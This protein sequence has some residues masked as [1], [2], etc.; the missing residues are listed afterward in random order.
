MK[1]TINVSSAET[2]GIVTSVKIDLDDEFAVSVIDSLKHL[3]LDSYLNNYAFSTPDKWISLY[4]TNND[5]HQLLALIRALSIL[6]KN[7]RKVLKKAADQYIKCLNN[8]DEVEKLKQHGYSSVYIM[9]TVLKELGYN[10]S[11]YNT[12]PHHVLL[13]KMLDFSL[14]K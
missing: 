6:P 10:E 11:I 12:I 5:N 14:L 9:V 2:K 13:N 3:C 4:L 8:K 7:E 1:V